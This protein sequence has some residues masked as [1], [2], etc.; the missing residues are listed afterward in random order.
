[1]RVGR[2]GAHDIR[3]VGGRVIDGLEIGC[4]T[5]AKSEV[6]WLRTSRVP[7]ESM[8]EVGVEILD[9]KVA[10]EVAVGGLD[11]GKTWDCS[12]P[13][14]IKDESMDELDSDIV[15]GYLSRLAVESDVI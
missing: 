4:Q 7:T 1:M 10:S 15:L 8:G 11:G 5:R 2:A 3:R 12:V 13:T 6:A 9:G 14:K